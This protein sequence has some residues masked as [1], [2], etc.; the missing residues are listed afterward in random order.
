[1]DHKSQGRRKLKN[2]SS[3]L[4]S[5]KEKEEM[6][7]KR[8]TE[9]YHIH[10]PS[11]FQLREVSKEAQ[12][13]NQTIESWSKGLRIDGQSEGI[14]KDLL[15]GAL[16]L[17]DSLVMLGKLQEAS[18]YMAHLKKKQIE[19]SERSGKDEVGIE[20]TFSDHYTET[21]FMKGFQRPRLST[22]GSSRNS[23]EELK[24][25][26]K[27]S[28]VRQNLL[29]NTPIHERVCLPPRL[30]DSASET[31]STSSSQSSSVHTKIDYA[32]APTPASTAAPQNTKG[33]NLIAKL[34]G[35]GEYPPKTLQSS[36][37][38][39]FEDQK[40]SNQQRPVFE[41]DRPKVRKPQS[42]LHTANQERN[43]KEI[44]ETMQFKGL[45]R[46]NSE[47]ELQPCFQHSSNS[48]SKQKVIDESPPIVLIRPLRVPCLERKE[49]HTPLF[50]EEE[51]LDRRK[52]LIKLRTKEQS[53]LK[54]ISHR[55]G[56]LKS[57][58]AH[59]KL[60][61]EETPIKGI[62]QEGVKEH[63]KIFDRPEEKAVGSKEKAPNKVKTLSPANYKP[64]KKEV[65][66]KKADKVQKEADL[67]RKSLE[68]EIVKTKH[69][70]KP[71]EQAKMSSKAKMPEHGSNITKHQISRQ[72]STKPSVIT[73]HTTQ[74]VTCNSTNQKKNHMKKERIVKEPA[75]AKSAT[76]NVGCKEDEKQLDLTSESDCSLIRTSSSLKDEHPKED[77]DTS[78]SQNGEHY[79]RCQSSP[80]DV[81][82]PRTDLETDTIE[83]VS[84][85][86]RPCKTDNLRAQLLSSPTFLSFVEEL[87]DL[88]PNTSTVSQTHCAE[89][90]G[91]SSMRLTLD[92]A[93]ELIKRKSSQYPQRFHPTLRGCISLED[94]LVEICNGIETLRNYSK[95]AGENLP[96]D[97]LFAILEKDT[98]C[99]GV[100]NGIWDS[101][102]SSEC[103]LDA[104]EKVVNDIEKLVLRGLIE[105]VIA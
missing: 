59:R 80:C 2:P 23:S 97:S 103:S 64:Q 94:L 22:D 44:L 57:D 86:I 68:K 29:P 61:A 42:E 82:L 48:H 39:Q 34:M 20:R 55:D 95:L 51:A 93:N 92:C 73:K 65:I 30:L 33:P 105:E 5:K 40:I 14:A 62:N 50:Q 8:V 16:D 58:K 27:E 96:V 101:G 35:L 6:P 102:W 76:K 53:T 47:K 78:G 9:E 84:N 91:A 77:A 26:I 81:S 79:S 87:F 21:N 54:T 90:F 71:Q 3:P 11:S 85:Y 17:Q 67:P 89:D 12:K 88:T 69:V 60:E 41:I 100:V 43:L 7:S 98:M 63:R 18:Q 10:S 28:L 37:Q 19:K 72:S 13:L 75:A 36:P 99:K 38:K 1:M 56:A 15:K 46:S 74:A 52:M 49:S 66:D 45:L 32:P 24:K 31:P 4:D 83:E 104:A 70:L 25:V